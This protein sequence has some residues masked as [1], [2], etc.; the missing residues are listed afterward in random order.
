MGD[1]VIVISFYFS[2]FQYR[3]VQYL[4]VL[5]VVML[6]DHVVEYVLLDILSAPA[7][8][9]QVRPNKTYIHCKNSIVA[10]TGHLL[11]EICDK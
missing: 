9:Q 4:T 7:D 10:L 11:L 5:S 3:R 2:P 1:S 6:L 8:A